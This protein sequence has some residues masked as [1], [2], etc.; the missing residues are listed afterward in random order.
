VEIESDNP[1]IAQKELV[2]QLTN[3]IANIK[4]GEAEFKIVGEKE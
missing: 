3:E 4:D 1:K 2:K